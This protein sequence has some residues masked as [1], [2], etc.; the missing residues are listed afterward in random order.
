MREYEQPGNCDVR[1]AE[2][3]AFAAY[4]MLGNRPVRR[5]TYLCMACLDAVGPWHTMEDIRRIAA[6]QR[7]EEEPEPD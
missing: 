6:E 2:L 3:S 1:G 4:D 5:Q 7:A